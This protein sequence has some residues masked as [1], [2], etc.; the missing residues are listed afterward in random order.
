M[1]ASLQGRDGQP[2]IVVLRDGQALLVMNI[3]WGYDEGEGFAHITT[4]IS[5]F[6]DGRDIDLFLT[7]DVLHILDPVTGATL[8]T[9]LS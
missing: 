9:A 3:A 1:L 6:Q 2:T 5:P 4:N 7:S 8:W